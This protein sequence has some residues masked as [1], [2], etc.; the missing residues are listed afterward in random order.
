MIFPWEAHITQ[1]GNKALLYGD[2]WQIP[3]MVSHPWRTDLRWPMMGFDQS[4][5]LFGCISAGLAFIASSC[6]WMWPAQV[7]HSMWLP[8][9]WEPGKLWNI[10]IHG[11]N[12]ECTSCKLK[13]VDDSNAIMVRFMLCFMAKHPAENYISTCINCFRSPGRVKVI[14]PFTLTLSLI[15]MQQLTAPTLPN[16]H[17]MNFTN[18]ASRNHGKNGHC[19]KMKLLIMSGNT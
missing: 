14:A 7:H 10:T 13:V 12:F 2:K 5:D 17:S 1:N 3:L 11:C 4:I 9:Y 19:P 15:W 18:F 8:P 6:W 16:N